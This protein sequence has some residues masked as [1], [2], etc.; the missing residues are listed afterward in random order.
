MPP[1]GQSTTPGIMRIAEAGP[2]RAAIVPSRSSRRVKAILLPISYLVFSFLQLATP[3]LNSGD[4]KK[5]ELI[6]AGIFTIEEVLHRQTTSRYAS[7]RVCRHR[8][9]LG[10]GESGA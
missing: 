5:L 6:S 4:Q 3:L 1:T 10:V 7:S 9:D 8:P 2:T